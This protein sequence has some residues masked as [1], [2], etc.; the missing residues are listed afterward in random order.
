MARETKGEGENRLTNTDSSSSDG[1]RSSAARCGQEESGG[2]AAKECRPGASHQPASQGDA[3]INTR[4]VRN[5]SAI[6]NGSS[7]SGDGRSSPGAE[8]IRGES[9]KDMQAIGLGDE[10]RLDDLLV[11]ADG[12]T[13][14]DEIPS[15][16]AGGHNLVNNRG[17]GE[18][19]GAAQVE[20]DQSRSFLVLVDLAEDDGPKGRTKKLK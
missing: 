20:G 10:S 7:Y 19:A 3:Q 13:D 6:L 1:Q 15:S 14:I 11:R 4:Q 2:I 5:P 12:T 9:S 18:G 8:A 17:V 16:Q